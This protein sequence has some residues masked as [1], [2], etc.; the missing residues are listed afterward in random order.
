M[1]KSSV[2]VFVRLY[3]SI[4]LHKVFKYSPTSGIIIA[5]TIHSTIEFC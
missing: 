3:Y 2:F 4:Y 1:L 5:G